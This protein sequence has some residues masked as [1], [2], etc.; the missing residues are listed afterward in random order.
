MKMRAQEIP[1]GV[2]NTANGDYHF[3]SAALKSKS[4]KS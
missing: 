4:V 1:I 2:F 3:Y